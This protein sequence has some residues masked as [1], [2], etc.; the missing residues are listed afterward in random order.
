[1]LR[2]FLILLV[3]CIPAQMFAQDYTVTPISAPPLNYLNQN[4]GTPMNLF[5]DEVRS[6]Q[7][8]FNFDFYG[9]TYSSAWISSNGVISFQ[10]PINGCCS[11]YNLADSWVESG[12]FVL[13]TDLINIDTLNPYTKL[14][15]EAGS[16]QYT[17]GWYDMPVFYDSNFRSTFE[18]TLFEGSNNI[19]IN[20]GDLNTQFRY[21]TAGIKGSNADGYE[22]IYSGSNGDLLDYSAYLFSPYAPPPPPPEVLY[23]SRIAGENESFILLTES[24]VRYGANGVYTTL[25]LEAG[26]HSC[27]NNL[28]GDPLGGVVKSCEVGITEPQDSPINCTLNLTDPSCIIQNLVD[29]NNFADTASA[30]TLANNTGSSDG[31]EVFDQMAAENNDITEQTAQL[32]LLSNVEE[33]FQEETAIEEGTTLEEILAE[34]D[35]RTNETTDEKAATSIVKEMVNEEKANT[36]TDSIS[37]STLEAALSIA[38]AAE[39][40]GAMS[41]TASTSRTSSGGETQIGV[42]ELVS[43]ADISIETIKEETASLDTAMDI[44]ETG[45]LIGR[46]ALETTMAL[47]EVSAAESVAQAENISVAS[48]ESSTT[49]SPIDVFA[50]TE[51]TLIST[52]TQFIGSNETDQFLVQ[53]ETIQFETSSD[54]LTDIVTADN[55][56]GEQTN[57][58]I[59]ESSESFTEIFVANLPAQTTADQSQEELE[60]QIIQQSLSISQ[61]Q[62]EDKISFSEGEAVTIAFDPNLAN[63]F[64]ISPNINNL[65]AAGVLNQKQEEK[66]D[67]ELRAEQV[68][69]AN[70]EEQDKIN[71]N[72]MDADQRGLVAAIG[73]DTDFTSYRSAMI[74]DNNIWYDPK[75]IYKNVTYKDNVRGMYF[76]EKGNTDTY[77]EMV[78]EQYK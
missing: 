74:R 42:S 62:D 40:T 44:L 68:V 64:N 63:A 24:Q 73:A 53:T 75:D 76:L 26:T 10:N 13:Q 72:Y 11:G 39:T 32:G 51:E 3:F 48:A 35:N 71:A 43:V 36:L 41:A 17:V 69:A 22:L 77:K 30:S 78:E 25:I 7:I 6:S 4:N 45:R 27:S 37:K 46:D 33:L 67:A 52:D 34:E 23:W 16:R 66:S 57:T 21:F 70:K 29:P 15:G 61:T 58:V 18:V 47:S 9:Q 2:R 59:N 55:I 1:M 31:S 14:V 56:P 50:T 12:I 8:G 54:Q 20:Y 60:L 49:V 28:F 5:D 65:E 38:S 19:L